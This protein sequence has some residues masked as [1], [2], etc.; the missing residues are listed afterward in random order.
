MDTKKI[1]VLAVFL[2]LAAGFAF[3]QGLWG[4][5]AFAESFVIIL[6]EGLEAMLVIAA[7]IAY[8]ASTKNES[9]AKTVYLS[10]L[11]A[12]LASIATAFVADSLLATTEAQLGLLEGATM[13]LASAVLLYVTNWLLGKVDSTN[14]KTYIKGKV[15]RAI[16]HGSGLALAAASFLAVYREGFETVLFFKALAFS[17]N[18]PAGI[19]LGLATGFVALAV[20]FILILKIEARLPLG[21]V[22]AISSALLF[23]LSLKFAGNGIHELQEGGFLN[24]TK[25]LQLPEIADAGFYP[26]IETLGL[27]AVII[28]IGAVLL[29]LHMKRPQAR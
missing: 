19:A 15:D 12:I 17:T 9:M 20:L 23:L 2:I 28:A 16:A 27:Q 7:I 1:A 25:F 29:F 21:L 18:D 6:R 3:A 10:A 11:A 13:L 4:G 5:T 24:E 8:L 26:T 14:W 22:F